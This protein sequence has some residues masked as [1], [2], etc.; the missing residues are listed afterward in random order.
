[1]VD[2]PLPGVQEGLPFNISHQRKVHQGVD[3]LYS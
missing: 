3:I 1:M 2:G